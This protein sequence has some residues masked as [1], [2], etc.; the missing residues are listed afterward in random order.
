MHWTENL[1]TYLE[2]LHKLSTNL[3]E[4]CMRIT[5]EGDSVTEEIVITFQKIKNLLSANG[6]HE[7]SILANGQTITNEDLLDQDIIIGDKWRF[8]LGKEEIAN[9]LIKRDGEKTIIFFKETEFCKWIEGLDPLESSSEHYLNSPSPVTFIING[10]SKPFGGSL[11][12]FFPL[13]SETALPIKSD[14][15]DITDIHQ[16]VH[17]IS[18]KPISISPRAYE[19][20]WGDFNSNAAKIILNLS[21]K[22]YAAS[23]V[24]DIRYIDGTYQVT[25]NGTKRLI[26]PL[27]NTEKVDDHFIKIL[28]DTV[29]WVYSERA[30][31]RLKLVMDRLSIDIQPGHS[32]LSGMIES[33][34]VALRQA[35][36]S[37]AFVIL[38]RKD[39]YHK[40]MREI[41]K[42][43][44]SQADLYASKVRDL[45]SNL[46]RDILG[47]LVFIGFSFIGKFDYTKIN[48][49]LAS[50][51]LSLLTGVLA[52]YLLVSCGLQMLNHWSDSSLSYSESKKWIFVLQNYTSLDDIKSRFLDPIEKRKL[53]LHFAM[54]I[55]GVLYFAL[56]LITWN[57]PF[58]ATLLLAQI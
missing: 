20:S 13:L 47:V 34:A 37:Y 24:H 15:P 56:I 50:R 51:E 30:E 31:T 44:K 32:L 33:I 45:I 2:D 39:A 28:K 18:N 43:M 12:W 35:K 41:M 42:D 53:T 3:I 4:E 29:A 19:L 11:V 17:I 46:T 23:L 16:L 9:R 10:L 58:I 26:L 22:V 57:L 48:E 21:A 54:L 36:D 55:C 8:I 6:L 1:A 7:P 25:L 5:I 38:E 14:L 49:L 52:I 27:S 40:E